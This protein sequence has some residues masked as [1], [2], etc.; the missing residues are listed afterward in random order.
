MAYDRYLAIC[1]PL[2]YSLIMSK[3]H[4]IC[5]VA[6]SYITGFLH[7]II[8][9]AAT[10]SSPMCQTDIYHFFCDIQPLLKLS[11]KETLTNEILL[12]TFTGFLT[13]VCLLVIVLSY[14]CIL[15]TILKMYSSG[16]RCRTFSTC[17]SHLVSVSLFYGSVLFMYMRPNSSYHDHDIS[18]SV[19]YSLIIPMLNPFIYSL[20]N[21]E[22]KMVFMKKIAVKMYCNAI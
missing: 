14:I 11:C 13:F 20:R 8:H 17:S 7:S 9:T 16:G 19:F 10:F 4:C 5:L 2:H 12:Y 15:N 18:A 21:R 1:Q 22:V 3:Y 6:I